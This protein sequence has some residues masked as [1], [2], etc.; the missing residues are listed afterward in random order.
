[1]K[2]TR[3]AILYGELLLDQP[4]DGPRVSVDTVLLSSYVKV[5]GGE[6][7][8]ELGSAHGAISLLLARRFPSAVIEGLEI[9][10]GLVALARKNA[11]G[12]GLHERVSF[13]E[14]DLR[15]IREI[16]P[17][18]SFSAVVVNPP[19]DEAASSRHSPRE[20]EAVARHGTQCT[21]EDVIR[22]AKYL[23]A[24]RGKLFL[25]LRAKRTA[26]LMSILSREHVEPKRIR[27]VYPSPGREASVILV[28]AA[29]AAGKGVILESPLYIQDSCGKYT[30]EL[31]KA[32]T[33]GAPQCP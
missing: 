22:A 21:L 27:P 20:S 6:K 7:V 25:V 15:R 9:Q 30:E 5:R 24:N 29:R 17:A 13:R 31:L 2:T 8:I 14:G 26:E 19:Y 1:M 23:L 16:Y 33:T 28:Q 3:D 12:N 10:P 32:Y 4:V 11:A 18:Q